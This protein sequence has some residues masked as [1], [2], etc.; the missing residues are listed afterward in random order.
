MEIIELP[1]E[2]FIISYPRIRIDTSGFTVNLASNDRHLQFKLRPE[3]TVHKDFHSLEGAIE[4]A[5][6]CV[7]VL[8]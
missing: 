6:R 1:Y 7:D 8:K 2:G 5:K 3:D 4:K